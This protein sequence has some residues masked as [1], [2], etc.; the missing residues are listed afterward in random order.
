MNNF[1]AFF[2]S[3]IIYTVC[4][5]LAIWLGFMLAGPLTYSAITIYGFLAFILVFPILLK[6]H[7]PLLVFAWYT[8]IML[9]FIPGGP[10]LWLAM[11]ALSLGISVT[12]RALSREMHFIIVPQITWPLLC[13]I[14]VMLVT[15]KLTGGVGLH[16]FGSEVYGGKKYVFMLI[17]I[18]SYFALTAQRIPPGRA[19][20]YV[21]LFFLSGMLSVIGDLYS[22]APS[23]LHF[24]FWVFPP[25]LYTT[26][27]FQIGETR[28]GGFTGAGLAIFYW[29]MALYGL[30]GIFLSN[31]LWRPLLFISSIFLIFLGGF[32]SSIMES[33]MIFM[34]I[35][36]LERLYRT[37]LMPIFALTGILAVVLM[38]SF[39]SHLPF[40]FQRALA[41]LPLELS[42]EARLAAQETSHWRIEMWQALLPQVPEHLLLGKG[43]AISH[44]DYQMMAQ[45]SPFQSV[46]AA[47]QGEALAF[48]YHNG[49]LSVLLG[50]GIWGAI[51]FLWFMTASLRVAYCNFRYGDPAL[52]TINTLLWVNLLFLFGRFLFLGGGIADDMMRFIGPLG[53][54]IALNG[55]VRQPVRA[56]K[57]RPEI[58]KAG[59]FRGLPSSPA[60]AFQR[61]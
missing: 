6:W 33:G 34:S 23:S 7:Y 52:R 10:N 59:S 4:V 30:R 36:F 1:P 17:G 47:Q 12:R 25:S 9:F 3:L 16:A 49:P 27:Q 22:L 13:M 5:V 11:V 61:R 60:P 2:R 58:P 37:R 40:T 35:F 50:F 21:S 38:I 8:N 39:A 14:G 44:E 15:A 42:P 48:D 24:I 43:F 57:P 55:G 20:F 53:L 28:L 29:L 26:G 45:Y 32:R 46:D 54:S 18:L 31:K 19:R 56:M 51:V 41:F